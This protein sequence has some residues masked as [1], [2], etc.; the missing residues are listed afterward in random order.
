MNLMIQTC[1]KQGGWGPNQNA[2]MDWFQAAKEHARSII[3]TPYYNKYTNN[4]TI[5]FLYQ[6]KEVPETLK[7]IQLYA[8]RYLLQQ[9]SRMVHKPA[10]QSR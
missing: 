3:I 10:P 1:G 5:P 7:L 2:F 9:C 8:Q 6:P 4:T